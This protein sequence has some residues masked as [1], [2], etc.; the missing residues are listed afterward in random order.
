MA[1]KRFPLRTK[2]YAAPDGGELRRMRRPDGIT[3]AT[4][5]TQEGESDQP[6]VSLAVEL[7]L[8]NENGNLLISMR[9]LARRPDSWYCTTSSIRLP[10]RAAADLVQSL[11]SLT[12]CL[13]P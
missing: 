2:I 10:P 1:T 7:Q 5:T 3:F 13:K 6:P 4:T 8:T 11:T 9:R 12:K